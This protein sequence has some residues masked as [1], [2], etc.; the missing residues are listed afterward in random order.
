MAQTKNETVDIVII[1]VAEERSNEPVSCS[2]IKSRPSTRAYTQGWD[3]V[4]G[5]PSPQEL[6]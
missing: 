3:R 5:K 1:L 6:N 4:F 2:T